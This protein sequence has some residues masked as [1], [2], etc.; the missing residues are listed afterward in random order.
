MTL[1]VI[2]SLSI[3]SLLTSLLSGATGMAGGL[4]LLIVFLKYLPVP[5]ALF[6]H[7]VIQFS[8]NFF[9]FYN[10]RKEVEWKLILPYSLAWI[11]VLLVLSFVDINLDKRNIFLCLSILP[12]LILF[13]PQKLNLNIQ[14]AKV[15]F[16]SHLFANSFQ[17]L[18]GVS[19]PIAS[20][21]FNSKLN[22]FQIL[23]TMSLF[24]FI[25]H[26]TKGVYYFP[27]V[28]NSTTDILA[29]LL[30]LTWAI[31]FSF[32]GNYWGKKI[33]THFEEKQFKQLGKVIILLVG[34]SLMYRNF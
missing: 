25:G 4:V 28:K 32:I 3:A 11:V 24:Q 18:I 33:V 6:F 21:F 9:R 13:S 27:A 34:L 22:R 20:L 15:N 23:G 10:Y 31:V 1:E 19:G 12:F 29:I 30:F 8:S 5:E 16:I 14:S 2:L 26:I 17:V 7:G